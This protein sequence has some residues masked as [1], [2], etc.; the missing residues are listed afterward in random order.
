MGGCGTSPG[1]LHPLRRRMEMVDSLADVDGYLNW[2]DQDLL[3][4]NN[5][6]P[7]LPL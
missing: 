4:A 7:W 6:H 3:A 1:P 2:P 5:R